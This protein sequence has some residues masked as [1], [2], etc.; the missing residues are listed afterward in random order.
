MA[1]WLQVSAVLSEDQVL[2]PSTSAWQL[3]ATFYFISMGSDTF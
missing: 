1:Q 2:V 3:T